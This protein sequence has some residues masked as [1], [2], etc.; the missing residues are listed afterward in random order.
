MSGY[1]A[2]SLVNVP[3]LNEMN[4]IQGIMSLLQHVDKGELKDLLDNEDQLNGIIS[5]NEEVKKIEGYRDMLM[6]GNRSLAEHNLSQKPKIERSKQMLIEAHQNKALIQEEFDK[7]RQKLEAISNQYSP[8]TTLALLQTSTAQAEEEAEKTADKFMDGE[9]NVEDFIQ[10][11]QSQKTLHHL[12][13]I[14][15][16]KLTELLRSR[17][18]SQYSYRF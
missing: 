8:D 1:G 3:R 16:E 17:T 4:A 5:D 11:F 13:K 2:P 9:M 10:T 6:A 18:S 7:N 15:T 12:R 14:K